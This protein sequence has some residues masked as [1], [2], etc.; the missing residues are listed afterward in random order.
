MED[1]YLPPYVDRHHI[2]IRP[3]EAGSALL[4]SLKPPA[5]LVLTAGMDCLKQEADTYSDLLREAGVKVDA[6]DYPLAKH[7]FSHYTKG[8]DFR[9]DDVEDCWKRIQGALESSL[10]LSP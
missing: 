3:L 1:S 7:G 8:Q 4:S 6:H 9:P 2:L 5:A 10:E